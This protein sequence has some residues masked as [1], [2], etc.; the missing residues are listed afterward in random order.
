MPI[1]SIAERRAI[2]NRVGNPIADAAPSRGPRKSL[3]IEPAV[4]GPLRR[5]RAALLALAGIA[6]LGAL[7]WA[8]SRP[9]LIEDRLWIGKVQAGELRIGVSGH[10]KLI[11][12]GLLT[13]S[14]TTGGSVA[15][16]H[17]LSG[18]KLAKGDAVLTLRN[19]DLLTTLS[20]A[21][22][23]YSEKMVAEAALQ[24]ELVTKRTEM[25][26]K[27]DDAN[28][29]LAV[30]R[31]ELDA[32]EK[33]F[34]S[35]ISSQLSLEKTRAR[36]S[37]AQR[38]ASQAAADIENLEVSYSIRMKAVKA[39][40]ETARTQLE[41]VKSQVDALTLRAP[42]SGALY[43]LMDNITVGTPITVGTV[44]A[45]I[46]TQTDVSAEIQIPSM[47]VG[48]VSA[49][50]SVDLR[51]GDRSITGYVQ[52]ID[53]RVQQDQVRVSVLLSKE[54]SRGLLAG[55]P[56]NGEIITARLQNTTYVER[57]AGAVDG[58]TMMLFEIDKQNQRLL[59][60]NVKFGR[61]GGGFIVVDSGLQVGTEIVLS[62][63][64]RFASY[65][66]LRYTNR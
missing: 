53:P 63:M 24:A 35:G 18:A 32:Q 1:E 3:Y 23:T 59:R 4:P 42:E 29:S 58:G 51:V 52:R 45:R 26:T 12:S 56:A 22:T 20:T 39:E 15:T 7:L 44:I 14:S 8:W 25:R 34:K 66:S 17:A 46:A 49:G 21:E 19:S 47:R 61:S 9:P 57:P 64:A 55:Q 62:D 41:R 16:I 10:G 65:H 37:A 36:V 31:L 33:L 38:Q 27:I 50:Q 2:D 13:L 60:R 54:A 6:V 43:E 30:E 48:D 5:Y 28:D 40:G 11:P